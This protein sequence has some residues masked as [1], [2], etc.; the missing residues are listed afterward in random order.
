MGPRSHRKT[1]PDVARPTLPKAGRGKLHP[2]QPRPRSAASTWRG[3]WPAR[4]PSSGSTPIWGADQLQEPWIDE[5]LAQYAYYLY[6]RD[7]YGDAAAAQRDIADA[8]DRL[9]RAEIPIGRPVSAYTLRQYRAIIY[10]RAPLFLEALARL[11]GEEPFELFLRELLRPYRW[12]LVDGQGFKSLAVELGGSDPDAL[13]RL[14]RQW[15][16]E[17]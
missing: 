13:E 1:R 9:R 5:S 3:P 6:C 7:R 17:P 12:R 14:W 8:W 4:S 2:L 15:V 10:G 16:D 11:M